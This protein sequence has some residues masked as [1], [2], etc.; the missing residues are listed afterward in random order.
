MEFIQQLLAA[1]AVSGYQV[2]KL[3]AAV[4]NPQ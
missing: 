2:E 3:L 1:Q 4:K